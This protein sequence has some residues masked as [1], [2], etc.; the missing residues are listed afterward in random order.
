MVGTTVEFAL[1]RYLLHQMS[2]SPPSMETCDMLFEATLCHCEACPATSLAQAV[3]TSISGRAICTAMS[4]ETADSQKE[5]FRKYLEQLAFE[6]L[7]ELKS[8]P[9]SSAATTPHFFLCISHVPRKNGIISQLTR[10]LVGLYEE[11]ERPG[12]A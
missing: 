11:P 10:V 5:E 7:C 3:V 1:C 12:N 4:Y 8:T 2:Q 6:H 9:N